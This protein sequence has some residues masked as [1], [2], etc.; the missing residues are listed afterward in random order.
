MAWSQ[1][2][3]VGTG[4][5][6]TDLANWEPFFDL[7]NSFNPVLE[8][9]G[10]SSAHYNYTSQA[11]TELVPSALYRCIA[12]GIS[13]TSL[14]IPEQILYRCL[15]IAAYC[16]DKDKLVVDQGISHSGWAEVLLSQDMTKFF[17]WAEAE[18]PSG[19]STTIL[20]AIRDEQISSGP[21]WSSSVVGCFSK[22]LPNTL[23]AMCEA[24]RK[25]FA[26]HWVNGGQHTGYSGGGVAQ[27]RNDFTSA[28]DS[29]KKG[30]TG[31]LTRNGTTSCE[32]TRGNLES[33]WDSTSC[34][35]DTGSS[36]HIIVE[37]EPAVPE[38]FD[39]YRWTVRSGSSKWNLVDM[40]FGSYTTTFRSFE[41]RMKNTASGAGL[42]DDDVFVDFFDDASEQT[43]QNIQTITPSGNYTSP[44][45]GDFCGSTFNPISALSCGDVPDDESARC[46]SFFAIVMELEV[47]EP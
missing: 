15:D 31:V 19:T 20:H 36:S 3:P 1:N 7:L 23:Y 4:W 33:L 46:I 18:L 11:F 5:C 14:I 16:F 21:D 37:Y 41:Y 13:S 30:S 38:F 44:Y 9:Y 39:P 17:T 32:T 27:F 2:I 34:T 45:V 25:N 12:G 35:S 24:L 6:F 28:S 47:A 10:E 43:I 8:I 22:D 26:V 40:N 42:Y 29:Q